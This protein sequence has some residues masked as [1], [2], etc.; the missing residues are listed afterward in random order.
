MINLI[1]AKSK[2]FEHFDSPLITD[3]F[4]TTPQNHSKFKIVSPLFSNWEWYPGWR[5]C[6]DCKYC[7]FSQWWL[8][9]C[10]TIADG[11]P[12]T[13]PYTL[14]VNST[15]WGPHGSDR[16]TELRWGIRF[17]PQSLRSLCY[18]IS[19]MIKSHSHNNYHVTLSSATPTQYTGSGMWRTC[20]VYSTLVHFPR[21]NICNFAEWKTP[22]KIR[23]RSYAMKNMSV[24]WVWWVYS[25]PRGVC[26]ASLVV[27]VPHTTWCIFILTWYHTHPNLI[28]HPP[29]LD[30][31]PTLL[32]W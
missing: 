31:T 9:L 17:H 3:T 27:C 19:R 20:V 11:T 2:G 30:T 28:P 21:F 29:R 16:P 5:T 13:P 10:R 32:T 4:K 6:S 14:M 18:W 15:E 24:Y 22:T 26:T 12:P 1:S 23:W 7:S 25:M 8:Q